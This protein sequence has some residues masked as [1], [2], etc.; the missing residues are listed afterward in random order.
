M[1]GWSA[2]FAKS[3]AAASTDTTYDAHSKS[4]RAAFRRALKRPTL[5]TQGK[6]KKK[7]KK[8]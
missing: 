2:A 6:R 1:A 7:R 4:E 5:W 8:A 3:S